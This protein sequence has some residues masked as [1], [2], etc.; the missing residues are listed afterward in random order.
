MAMDSKQDFLR[1]VERSL[2]DSVTVSD[3]N[4]IMKTLANVM[5]N[6]DMR[7]V[8]QWPDEKDDCLD[9]FLSALK[10]E[11]RSQKTIDRYSENGRIICSG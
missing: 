9:S 5:E 2:S 10:V 1:N 11:G 3:M 4:T 7:M 8:T 6:Y